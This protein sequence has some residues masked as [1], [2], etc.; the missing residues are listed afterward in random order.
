MKDSKRIDDTIINEFKLLLLQGETDIICSKIMALEHEK[1]INEIYNKIIL[2]SIVSVT[3]LYE[4]KKI[5]LPDLL[6]ASKTYE[7]IKKYFC[8][9]YETVIPT[10][11][12]IVMGTVKNDLHDIGKNI[13]CMLLRIYELEVID[14]G[15][16]VETSEFVYALK[17]EKANILGM[18][19][20][21]TNT[22][23]QMKNVVETIRRDN[24]ISD[25]LIMVGGAPMT[26]GY[27]KAIGA[28]FYSPNAVSAAKWA[29]KKVIEPRLF[30]AQP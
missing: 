27:A 23:H 17:E 13:V 18:S 21:L 5:Y 29:R 22:M 24:H 7:D 10:H 15:V 3:D 30:T 26:E 12:K 1:N 11:G 14:L 2:K 6:I 28:D 8:S 9:T 19:A 16:D 25:Y 20:M 4:N